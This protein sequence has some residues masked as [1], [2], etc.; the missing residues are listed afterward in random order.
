MENFLTKDYKKKLKMEANLESNKVLF[1]KDPDPTTI[2][3]WWSPEERFSP[4][5]GLNSRGW[6]RV[7]FI[8]FEGFPKETKMLKNSKYQLL[9]KISDKCG[10]CWLTH[11]K[12]LQYDA[13]GIIFDNTRYRDAALVSKTYGPRGYGP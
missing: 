1:E 4:V 7:V 9:E 13:A 6:P 10:G 5:R 3:I 12:S 2:L 8:H 11:D